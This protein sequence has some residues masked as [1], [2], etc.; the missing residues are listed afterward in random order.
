MLILVR[1]LCV[2][3]NKLDQGELTTG[4]FGV[5]RIGG[6]FAIG[7]ISLEDSSGTSL[8]II[9]TWLKESARFSSWLFSSTGGAIW[10]SVSIFVSIATGLVLL[11]V[12]SV[13][14]VLSE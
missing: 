7:R 11:S 10:L 14:V 1:L 4:G 6:L 12:V 3:E 2:F 9:L 8:E 5:I 13:I